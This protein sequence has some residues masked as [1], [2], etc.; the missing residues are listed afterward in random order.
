M[1]PLQVMDSPVARQAVEVGRKNKRRFRPVAYA[2]ELEEPLFF[3][4]WWFIPV[5]EDNAFIPAEAT[6]RVDML[7]DAGIEVVDLIVAHETTKLLMPPPGESK[8]DKQKAKMER[9]RKQWAD[10]RQVVALVTV[11]AI[12]ALSTIALIMGFLISSMMMIDP[13]LIAVV[14]DEDGRKV[15]I[16]VATWYD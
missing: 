3:N 9:R 2:D 12:A 8:A 6:R 15:W 14:Q 11:G 7:K 4:D 1:N 5:A 13:A 10:G 16:E